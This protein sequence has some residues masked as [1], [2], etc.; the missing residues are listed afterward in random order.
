MHKQ[1]RHTH[2]MCRA[3]LEPSDAMAMPVG[4]HLT[5]EPPALTAQSKVVPNRE[6]RVSSALTDVLCPS[7]TEATQPHAQP[8]ICVLALGAFGSSAV[9][10]SHVGHE[11]LQ[12][13]DAGPVETRSLTWVV[14][15]VL[16]GVRL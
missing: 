3:H 15:V 7:Q 1:K 9:G 4:C 10:G 2:P 16:S 6:S 5:D 12:P 8:P 11:T 14:G 13:A